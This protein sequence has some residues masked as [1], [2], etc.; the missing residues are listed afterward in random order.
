MHAILGAIGSR[1]GIRLMRQN[2]GVAV[3]LSQA[4]RDCKT[5]AIRF[6]V[7]GQADLMGLIAPHGRA[8]AIEVKSASGR[9]TEEQARF[10]AMWTKHGGLYVLA[11]SVSDAEAAVAAGETP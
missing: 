9:Q 1:P 11:R 10:E 6:G 4:C 5:R 7:V 3:P 8:L 2:V